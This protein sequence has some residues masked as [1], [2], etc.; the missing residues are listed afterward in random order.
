MESDRVYYQRR[1]AEEREAALAASHPKARSAHIEMA[2]DY[3]R[4]LA[5]LDTQDTPNIIRL[6]DVA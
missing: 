1:A 3:D 2:A 4:R 5:D 6:I